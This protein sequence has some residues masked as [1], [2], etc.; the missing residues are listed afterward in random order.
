MELQEAHK[1]LETHTTHIPLSD[2]A[3]TLCLAPQTVRK[4]IRNGSK[5][6]YDEA[7]ILSK[8]Y[9]LPLKLFFN[10]N[11]FPKIQPIEYIHFSNKKPN[12]HRYYADTEIL[13]SHKRYTNFNDYKIYMMDSNR[14][15][16]PY[17]N[18]WIKQGDVVLIDTS[19]TNINN[20][21]LYLYT[22]NN[23][24]YKNISWVEVQIDGTVDF[25]FTYPELKT[26][27]R[28]QDWLKQQGFKVWGRVIKNIN[29]FA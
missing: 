26:E 3:K 20:S 9:N 5:L 13:Y 25:T 12:F 28:T 23:E 16:L 24:K 15:S 10:A 21:G 11:T 29:F 6:T 19:E 1:L 7:H 8:E 17:G 18:L 14:L 4:R 22:C 27:N 2:F